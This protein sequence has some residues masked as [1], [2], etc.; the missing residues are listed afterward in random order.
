MPLETTFL[1]SHNFEIIFALYS[2]NSMELSTTG[3]ATSCAAIVEVPSVLWDPKVYYRVHKNSPHVPI[4]IQ[5]N[6]VNT[7]AYLSLQDNSS[8]QLHLGLPSGL[9]SPLLPHSC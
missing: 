1:I 7:P 6:P 8:T 4:Q 5:T 2:T 3:E 9:V